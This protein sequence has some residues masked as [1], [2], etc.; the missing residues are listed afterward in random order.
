MRFDKQMR[1]DILAGYMEVQIYEGYSPEDVGKQ[2]A[3]VYAAMD[4]S[5]IS[6]TEGMKVEKD[7]HS[8]DFDRMY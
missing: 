4:E 6:T 3:I 7:A 8:G 1:K 5:T 2:A